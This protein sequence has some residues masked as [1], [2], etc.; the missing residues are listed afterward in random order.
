M[1][2]TYY[3]LPACSILH[4]FSRHGDSGLGQDPVLLRNHA[5]LRC[6]KEG[7]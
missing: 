5:R 7:S 3:G 6:V 2:N 4:L 1:I